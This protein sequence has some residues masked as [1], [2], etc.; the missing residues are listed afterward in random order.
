MSNNTLVIGLAALVIGS[1]GGY[2][3]ANVAVAPTN[4]ITRS[5]QTI[6]AGMHRM[7][8][9]NMMM[10]GNTSTASSGMMGHG[11]MMVQSER[12]FL[13]E[14]I[15][16]HEEA[17][18]TAKEVLARGGTT[19]EIRTL[20]TN[21]ITAQE[22]EIAD[23]KSWYEAWY[24][25]PYTPS[26]TYQPMMRDLENLSGT[27]LDRAFL[28]DMIMHHMGAIMMA[29]GVSRHIEHSEIRTLSQSIIST[30]S[31]EITTMK[32]LLLTL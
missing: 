13:T 20:A 15:P 22:K 23:M 19:E 12:E 25:T 31:T 2:L 6:P 30:Q 8:D 24:S 7:P 1:V 9:G 16:H 32:R 29:E 17:V 5:S 21:I 27:A 14:M 28:E 18:T 10:N 4:E 3:V 26:G 11:M